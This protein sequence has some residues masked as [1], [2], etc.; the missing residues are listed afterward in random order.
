PLQQQLDCLQQQLADLRTRLQ[1]FQSLLSKAVVLDADKQAQFA[2]TAQAEGVSLP[3][4]RVLL[5]VF[6]GDKAPSVP[7]LGRF[8]RQAGLRAGALLE[9]LDKHARP[10]ARQASA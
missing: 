3:V 10:L 9:V 6:L 2:A 7:Q 1:Q 8:S 4:T 5:S